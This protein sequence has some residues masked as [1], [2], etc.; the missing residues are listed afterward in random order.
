VRIRLHAIRIQGVEEIDE[1]VLEDTQAFHPHGGEDATGGKGSSSVSDGLAGDNL[2]I[3]YQ[4]QPRRLIKD[5]EI[6]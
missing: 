2:S 1:G 4:G 6:K 5:D 3:L